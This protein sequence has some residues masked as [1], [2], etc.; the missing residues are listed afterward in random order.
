MQ[1]VKID[2]FFSCSFRE[3]DKALNEWFIAVCKALDVFPTNVS[4]GS[5]KTPPEEAKRQITEAQALVAVCTC[6]EELKNGGFRMPSAVHDEISF[7]YGIDTPVLLFVEEGVI[8]DGFKTNFSTYQTFKRTDLNDAMF[9]ENAVRAIHKLK[10]DVLGPHQM[11]TAG[12]M[13]D[14]IAEYIYHS[15]ELKECGDDFEWNYTTAKK[16]HFQHES[17]RRFPSHVWAIGSVKIPEDS[18][19]IDWEFQL[20][21]SSNNIQVI[22]EIEEQSAKALKVS[23]KPTPH[24]QKDDFVE[25]SH[26]SRSRYLNSVWSDEVGDGQKEHLDDKDFSCIDGLIFIHRTKKAVIEFRFDRKYP[27]GIKEIQPFA[28]SYTSGIDYEVK[29]ELARAIIRQ[30]DFVGTKVIRMEIDSPLPGHMYGIAWD[31]PAKPKSQDPD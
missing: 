29:S 11:G 22:D 23:L 6:R 27:I 20:K 7:A 21:S 31:P 30:E 9:V 15:V 14:A 17:K 2:A 12:G 16:M 28:A 25:F 13:T 4:T 26:T 1:S 24:P 8:I 18:R 3:D 5:T 19:P 10:L